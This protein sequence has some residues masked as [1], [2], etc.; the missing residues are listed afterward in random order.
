M[1]EGTGVGYVLAVPKSQQLYAPFGRIDFTIAQAP[2]D[3]WERLSCGHGA[4]GPR[5]YDWA[6][7]RLPAAR[8]HLAREGLLTVPRNHVE[9]LALKGGADDEDQKQQT[10]GRFAGEVCRGHRRGGC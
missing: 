8:Q 9:H 1:L 4:K 6:A 10:G 7:A 2:E 3:A 5:A